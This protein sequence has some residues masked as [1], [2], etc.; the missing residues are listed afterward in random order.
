MRERGIGEDRGPVVRWA[1]AVGAGVV[2]A[3]AAT[4]AGIA[5]SWSL[6]VLAPALGGAV[7]GYLVRGCPWTGAF[8]GVAACGI[9]A[10]SAMAAFSYWLAAQLPATGGAGVALAI[11]L[12]AILVG[13]ALATLVGGL[14]GA[15]GAALRREST[16]GE[17][18]NGEDVRGA[19]PRNG[20]GGAGAD[21]SRR[22]SER[23]P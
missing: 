21:G 16:R 11:L 5:T 12:I 6:V 18:W 7:A 15:A 2:V 3:V 23:E 22:G 9:V 8:A 4:I 20:A 1:A 17:R 14:G 19:D 13:G 10:L